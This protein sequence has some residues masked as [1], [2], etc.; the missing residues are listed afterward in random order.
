MNKEL[1]LR[2]ADAIENAEL[3]P[4]GIGFNMETYKGSSRIWPDKSG[5]NCAT[6]ACIAGWTNFLVKDSASFYSAISARLFLG[7]STAQADELFEPID[8]VENMGLALHD[9]T[10]KQAV[11]CLRNLAATGKVDWHR[12]INT[13]EPG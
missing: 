2:V 3:A 12:A 13:T 5:H 10:P 6:V 9:I 4:Q 1:I 7:L 11:R 8:T